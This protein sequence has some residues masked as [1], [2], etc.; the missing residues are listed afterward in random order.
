MPSSHASFHEETRPL[1][2][3]DES[4][5]RPTPPS[6][7]SLLIAL[8]TTLAAAFGLVLGLLVI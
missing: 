6:P 1:A 4:P 3:L 8:A 5:P 7:R 2:L